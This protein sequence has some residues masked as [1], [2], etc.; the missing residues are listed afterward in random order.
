VLPKARKDHPLSET[1]FVLPVAAALGDREDPDEQL[2]ARLIE[3]GVILVLVL[4]IVIVACS[5]FDAARRAPLPQRGC[6]AAM[7]GP[8]MAR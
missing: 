3:Q 7:G 8:E 1:T 4:A 5:V 6:Y 2:R